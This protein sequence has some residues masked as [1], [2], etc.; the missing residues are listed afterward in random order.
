M[1]D[2][3]FWVGFACCSAS[4]H[5]GESL[6]QHV[7]RDGSFIDAKDVGEMVDAARTRLINTSGGSN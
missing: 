5:V 3:S 4:W 1:P 2:G 6:L 7:K